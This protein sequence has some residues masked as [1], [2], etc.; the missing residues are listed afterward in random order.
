[1]T[2]YDAIRLFTKSLENLEKCMDKA[3]E[4]AKSRSFEVDVLDLKSFAG[5][6]TPTREVGSMQSLGLALKGADGKSYTFRILDKGPTKILPPEWQNSWPAKIFQD[7]TAAQHPGNNLIVPALAGS[8]L[9]YVLLNWRAY[10][11]HRRRIWGGQEGGAAMYGGLLLALALSVPLV[12]LFDLRWAAFWDAGMVTI[13]TG[14]IP[15]R[16]GCLL[17][18]CCGGRPS[19]SRLA[20]RLPN[21]RGDWQ[22]RLPLQVIEGLW[23]AVLLAGL[24]LMWPS[25]PFE[26]AVFLTGVVGYAAARLV[27]EPLRE[28]TDRLGPIRVHSAISAGLVAASLSAMAALWPVPPPG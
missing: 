10:R 6:L 12:R 23:A 1:M 14:M 16:V 18:G 2:P 19:S 20:I 3:S 28:D 27:I 21:V 5:G 26:G 9:L 15:T 22:P 11:R 4:Y 7:Q 8:R 13:L 24:A 17:N 25:R